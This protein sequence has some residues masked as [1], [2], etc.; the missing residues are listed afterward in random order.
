MGCASF[1]VAV[2]LV[3]GLAE[4]RPAL[5]VTSV[6]VLALAD[7]AA[8]FVGMR[9]G[10]HRYLGPGGAKSLEGSAAFFAAATLC[11]LGTHASGVAGAGAL[12]IGLAVAAAATLLEAGSPLGSD[13]ITVPVGTCLLLR[14]WS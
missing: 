5:Y 1:P 10:R 12:A 2:A 8:A 3:F 7:P 4:R 14:A 9:F 6:L 13:N 11:V